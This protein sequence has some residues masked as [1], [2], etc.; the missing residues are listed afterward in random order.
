VIHEDDLFGK[1][2]KSDGTQKSK[3]KRER[4]SFLLVSSYVCFADDGLL[5]KPTEK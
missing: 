4:I 1:N 3:Q 2:K 5:S